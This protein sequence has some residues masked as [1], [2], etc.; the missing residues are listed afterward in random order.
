MFFD[1][2]NNYPYKYRYNN[3]NHSCFQTGYPSVL[4]AGRQVVNFFNTDYLEAAA[5]QIR[6]KH[7]KNQRLKAKS[8][9]C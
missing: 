9:G 4:P 3:Q 6:E 7:A 2:N 1:V 5:N 8:N